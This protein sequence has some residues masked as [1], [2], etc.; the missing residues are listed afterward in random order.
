MLGV[1]R[2]W[3]KFSFSYISFKTPEDKAM[4]TRFFIVF[5]L[6]LALNFVVFSKTA[7]LDIRMFDNS[8]MIVVIDNYTFDE[9]RSSYHLSNLSHGYRHIEIYRVVYNVYNPYAPASTQLFYS[10]RIFLNSGYLTFAEINRF[11]KLVILRKERLYHSHHG[12]NGGHNGNNSYIGGQFG[13]GGHA[14]H[15]G[16]HPA[17]FDDLKRTIRRT[18]FDS[19]RLDIAKFAVS[20]NRMTSRQVAELTGLFT[21]ESNRLEFAKYAFRFVTDP[22]SYYIVA[23]AFTFSSSKRELFEYM[24]YGY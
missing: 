15:H 2:F 9:G 19:N 13:Y 14:N 10:G 22:G 21:F 12:F 6:L 5:L 11:G 23:D 7:E 4:K 16:M 1:Y 20:G 18:S 24:G 8:P 3:H 17:D